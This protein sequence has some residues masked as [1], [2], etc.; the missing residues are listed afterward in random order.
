MGHKAN[1]YLEGLIK[2]N[3]S[4]FGIFTGNLKSQLERDSNSN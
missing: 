4:N 3:G 2:I 1:I